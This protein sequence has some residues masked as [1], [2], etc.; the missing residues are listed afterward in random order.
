MKKFLSILLAIVMV[1]SLMPA[2]FAAGVPTTYNVDTEA[3]LKDAVA[4]AQTGDTIALLGDV[5]LTGYLGINKEITI[6]LNGK[7]INTGNVSYAVYVYT[8]GKLT[9][10]DTSAEKTGEISGNEIVLYVNNGAQVTLNAG[11]LTSPADYVVFVKDSTFTMNGGSITASEDYGIFVQ[12]AA[13]KRGTVVITGGS[14]TA[15]KRSIVGN[16]GSDY[17]KC[18]LTITGGSVTS[19]GA[20]EAGIYWPCNGKLTIAGG[21]ITGSTGVYVKSGSLEITNG[22]INGT[23]N[24]NEYKYDKSGAVSTGDAI[25]IENVG[26]SSNFE[27]IGSVSISGGTFNSAKAAAVASY[28]A[29]KG[30]EKVVEFITGGTFSS[31]VSS[32]YVAEGYELNSNGTVAKEYVGPALYNITKA[33]CE[34]G[35]VTAQ[36]IMA[37]KGSNIKVSAVPAE[38]Y[39]V[40]SLTV[41]DASGKE[42]EIVDGKFKMP[43]SAVTVSATFVK[44]YA[45]VEIPFTDM[46]ADSEYHDSVAYMDDSGLMIGTSSEEAVFDGE[47]TITRAQI[48][49]ILYRL[50]GEPETAYAGTF[51]DASESDWYTEAVE[52]AASQNIIK[53]MGD[54]TFAPNTDIT[55]EQLAAL[56]YRYA[57]CKLTGQCVSADWATES[58]AAM[59]WC[60]ENGV[61]AEDAVASDAAARY[62]AAEMFYAVDGLLNK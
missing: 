28:T 51:T 17:D 12:G 52:W 60:V 23:G 11:K 49:M 33:A 26:G 15:A 13:G 4:A 43:A 2:A 50:A 56:V 9:I 14:V 6:D 61:L 47:S 55:V 21:T 46:A 45:Q 62:L 44:D 25:V 30:E 37:S 34:N 1:V 35:K 57:Q 8:A 31:D 40:A 36:A 10:D 54:G 29:N 53:G 19:N 41:T 16:G 7:T 32:D 22:I 48:A 38:G 59:T 5:T 27:A 3:E 58:V 39:K 24:K 42:I 20:D 18:D